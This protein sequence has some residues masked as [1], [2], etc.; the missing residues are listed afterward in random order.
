V[1]EEVATR[2]HQEGVGGGDRELADNPTSLIVAQREADSD[3]GPSVV[4]I[5]KWNLGIEVQ[6]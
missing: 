3:G 6:S 2:K 1:L 5:G 4:L